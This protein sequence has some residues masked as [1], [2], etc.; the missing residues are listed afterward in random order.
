MFRF[1]QSIE[2][3]LKVALQKKDQLPLF[4]DIDS[5]VEGYKTPIWTSMRLLTLLSDCVPPAS[6]RSS[7]ISNMQPRKE[8]RVVYGMR[9]A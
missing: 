6:Q 7:A 2:K 5:L 3:E 8:L 9:I 4:E 1:A